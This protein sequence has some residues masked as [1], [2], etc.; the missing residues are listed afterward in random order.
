MQ[1]YEFVI[2]IGNPKNWGKKI[3]YSALKSILH[4]AFFGWKINKLV[5]KIHIENERSINL[6]KHLSFKNNG[7][8]NSH[9]IFSIT[10]DEYLNSLK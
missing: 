1:E 4:K 7:V 9:V 8:K 3:G 10:F 2:A 6:F 5:A